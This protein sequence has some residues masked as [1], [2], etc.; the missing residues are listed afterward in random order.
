MLQR[1]VGENPGNATLTRALGLAKRRI[2]QARYYE[3]A[4]RFGQILS[5]RFQ[6]EE[7]KDF[8]VVTGGVPGSMAAAT[9]GAWGGG[10]R[11]F[12]L[13][14]TLPPDQAP[15]PTSGRG[16]AVHL[17]YFG[18]EEGGGGQ[19]WVRIGGDRGGR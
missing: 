17:P 19:R 7:R 1:G 14:I 13:N 10:A 3:Q 8:V 18:T 6:Q 4:R 12:G 2:A 11:S 5:L 16:L 9:R 15:T